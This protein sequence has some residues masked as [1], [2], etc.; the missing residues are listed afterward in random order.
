[1]SSSSSFLPRWARSS[2]NFAGDEGPLRIR[3]PGAPATPHVYD[4]PADA[5]RGGTKGEGVV[6]GTVGGSGGVTLGGRRRR[7]S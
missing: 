6:G 5:C 4:H 1:M 2:C 7:A 3:R